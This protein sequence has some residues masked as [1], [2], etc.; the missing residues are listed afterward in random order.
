MRRPVNAFTRW[1]FAG[2]QLSNTGGVV[3]I[4]VELFQIGTNIV[5]PHLS[6]KHVLVCSYI[7]CTK[8]TGITEIGCIHNQGGFPILFLHVSLPRCAS[9]LLCFLL[10]SKIEPF[11]KRSVVPRDRYSRQTGW[12]FASPVSECLRNI[13]TIHVLRGCLYH[14]D[15]DRR[16]ERYA[17]PTQ[18]ERWCF[19]IPVSF[20]T[21][22]NFQCWHPMCRTH[23]T[24]YLFR[25]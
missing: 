14:R 20:V 10:Q 18:G 7:R 19:C 4:Y 5:V 25:L 8:R 6:A 22:F 15:G 24:E 11:V 1:V 17:T 13:S 12:K 9:L 21:Q 2:P 3:C 16:R 23:D